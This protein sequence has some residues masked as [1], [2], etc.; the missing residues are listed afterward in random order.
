MLLVLL[1]MLLA[2]CSMCFKLC[3]MNRNAITQKCSRAHC[4][5]LGR[6]GGTAI[7][8]VGHNCRT[9]AANKLPAM[10]SQHPTAFKQPATNPQQTNNAN[11]DTHTHTTTGAYTRIS[12]RQGGLACR[13]TG[14]QLLD[15]SRQQAP[16]NQNRNASEKATSNQPERQHPHTTA[17]N[18]TQHTTNTN[19]NS[20]MVVG[21]VGP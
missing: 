13:N 7:V 5:S 8:A 15:A 21:R 20:K 11:S 16:S 10:S 18:D 3:N 2:L 12:G 6:Q 17:N 14:T 9:G 4:W 19:I 1:L